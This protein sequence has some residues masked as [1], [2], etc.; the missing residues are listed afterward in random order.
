VRSGLGNASSRKLVGWRRYRWMPTLGNSSIGTKND[1]RIACPG[2]VDQLL[3]LARDA[4]DRRARLIFFCAC[5]SPWLTKCH[6][7]E[8][9]R[10]LRH[11]ARRRNLAVNIEEWPGGRPN[12]RPH[13]LRVSP[14]ILND[15]ERGAK[16]VPLQRKRV[17]TQF[18]AIPWGTLVMLKAGRRE[19]P[20]RSVQRHF[21]DRW[22]LPRFVDEEEAL[23][24]S[25][26]PTLRREAAK[27]RRRYDLY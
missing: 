23:P 2:A 27:L 17:P 5:K 20:C 3:D 18:V 9:A 8:V 11:S 1:M 19:F 26:L 24:A 10:L 22:V 6:R 4:A 12:S 16:A 25:S 21:S 14:E 13:I 15:M 7:H